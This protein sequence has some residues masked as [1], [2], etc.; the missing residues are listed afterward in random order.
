MKYKNIHILFIALVLSVTQLIAQ[1][2]P[3]RPSPPRLVNDYVGLLSNQQNKHL[4][5]KLVAFNDTNST[6]IAI[7]IVDDLKGYD[8]ADYAQRVAQKWGIGQKKYDNG[9]IIVLKPKTATTKGDINIDVGYGLE[10]IIPDITTIR[11]IENEMI[12]RF[13]NDDYFGGLDAGT[14]VMISL[15]AGQFTADQYKDRTEGGG[16]LVGFFVPLIVMIIIFSMINRRR[17]NYYN[18]T[19][20]SSSLPLWTAL[21]MGSMMGGSRGGSWGNF[22]SGSGGFGGGG[23]FGGFGGGGFGGG[24]ASGSW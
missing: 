15:A 16:G 8:V 7:L 9:A 19:G 3:E 1:D 12:P 20:K 14:D 4:E 13:S 18:T 17:N 21:W 11:I 23:G 24:G 10:P 22:S 5:R 2:I 6:Q